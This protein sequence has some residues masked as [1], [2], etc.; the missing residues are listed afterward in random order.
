M[1]FILALSILFLIAGCNKSKTNIQIKKE[2]EVKVDPVVNKDPQ[3]SSTNKTMHMTFM[4]YEEGD[5]PHVI[6]KDETTGEEYDFR[7]LDE[8]IYG[9]FPILMD[10]PDAAFGFKANPKY[11]NQSFIVEAELKTV[12]DTDLN[13]EAIKA[14]GWV[15]KS[16]KAIN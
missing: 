5:Y 1:K 13:G 16:L 2:N 8:N 4:S 11:V 3:P 14:E 12:A 9:V 7:Y 15:I 6:F 10:D